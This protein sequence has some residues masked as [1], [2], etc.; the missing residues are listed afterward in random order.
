MKKV[1]I[2]A[3]TG[4][5]DFLFPCKKTFQAQG[6]LLCSYASFNRLPVTAFSDIYLNS[7]LT[8]KGYKDLHLY[9]GKDLFIF[10]KILLL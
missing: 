3:G 7:V 4:C 1:Q 10:S 8:L 2:I 6:M 9:Y 5:E